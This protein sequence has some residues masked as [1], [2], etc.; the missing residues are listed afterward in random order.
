MLIGI[1]SCKARFTYVAMVS[2]SPNAKRTRGAT[3]WS[4]SWQ[5]DRS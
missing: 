4:D 1:V 2:H 5:V 3:L